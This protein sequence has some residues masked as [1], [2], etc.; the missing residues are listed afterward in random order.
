[1]ATTNFNDKEMK[2]IKEVVVG[3]LLQNWDE[4]LDDDFNDEALCEEYGLTE[5]E[6]QQLKEKLT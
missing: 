6:L 1:M 2:F 3:D 4:Y 5:K